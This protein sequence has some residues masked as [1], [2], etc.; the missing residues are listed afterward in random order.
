MNDAAPI[1]AIATASGRGGIGVVRVSGKG[2]ARYAEQVLKRAAQPRMAHR[3]VLQDRDGSAIDDGLLLFFAGPSSYTGEDV[4]EF[5]G[6]GGPVVM[7]AVQARWL[8]L[9]PGA[10]LA[11]PG[12]FT[13]RAFLNG[14]LDLA[15][16]EAVAD[17]IDA[18]SMQAA[19]GAVH[20]LQGVFSHKVR[21]LVESLTQLRTLV[22]A[23]LDFPEEEIEFL[24]SARALERLDA[25]RAQLDRVLV[26]ARQGAVLRQGLQVVLVGE[27]NVGKS[28]VLNALAGD[29]VAIVTPIAGTTRDRIVQ[30]IQVGGVLLNVVDTAGLR[31][32]ADEVE[33]LGIE[34]TWQAVE[35]ADIVLLLS[36][37]RQPLS[38]T[39]SALAAQ[40]AQRAP[41]ARRVVV[42][43]KSD[44]LDSGVA[45]SSEGLLVSAKTGRGLDAL[46]DELL[47]TA[48]LASTG[49]TAFTARQ[50]H[51]GALEVAANHLTQ[52]VR[53]GEQGDE[54]LELFAEELRLAQRSLGSI[55][56]E[57]SADDLL[58]QIFS[59]F[60][61]GK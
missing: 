14:K 17:L 47:A 11:A 26:Q 21:E 43:N 4:I 40:V 7:Q 9:V 12:E 38:E 61:I 29:D 15:Q 50:R 46:R 36:D 2:L 20:S 24:K 58:G 55:T 28:S 27:P 16:A 3:L 35:Q 53:C 54:A 41:N 1:V 33:R 23:T 42:F 45:K 57:L 59:T 37:A 5:H 60:C 10:R 51:V 44:L 8:E 49:E 39:A 6:H 52:A 19:R 34:R 31:D 32:T 48:G 25:I 18:G 13:E 30:P 56:G 22:E